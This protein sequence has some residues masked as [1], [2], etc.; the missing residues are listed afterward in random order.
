MDI[1]FEVDKIEFDKSV[2]LQTKKGIQFLE[3]LSLIMGGRSVSNRRPS[4]PQT[5]ALTN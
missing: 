2:L 3:S 4:V 1:I 5:D